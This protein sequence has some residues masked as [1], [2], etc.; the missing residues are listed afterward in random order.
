MAVDYA[1]HSA[2]IE[3][4]REELEE[5][6]SPIS[7]KPTEIPLHSTVSGEPIEGAEL[8]PSYWY[9]NL[10]Q[11]VLLEPVLRKALKQGHRALIEIGPHPV[12]AFGAQ[13]TIDDALKDPG[14]AT[15]LGTLRREEDEP[16]RFALSLAE[17]HANGIELDWEAFFKGTE[18]KR[19]PLPTYPFQRERYWLAPS[20]GSEVDPLASG[21]AFADHPLL[22]ATVDLAGGEEEGLLLTGRISLQTHPWLADHAVA[23]SVLLPGTAFLEMALRAGAQSGAETV[24][25][26]TLQKPLILPEPGAVAIQVSVSGPTEDGRR[27]LAIYS[28]IEGE[29]GAWARHASGTLSSEPAADIE[30]L[31]AWPPEGSEPL[32]VEY[33]YDVLAEHGFEYGPLFQ[34]LTAA[35]RDGEGVCVEVSLPEE[36]AHEAGRF[37]IHPALLDSALHGMALVENDRPGELRLPFSWSGVSVRAEGASGLRVRLTPGEESMALQIA[38]GDGTP[39]AASTRLSCGRWI[40]L[41]CSGQRR[42]VRASCGSTGPRFPSL[43]WTTHRSRSSFCAAR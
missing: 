26:L 39:L 31:E 16:T 36:S 19:V 5:A 18:A 17:A 14:E 38:D 42:R 23:G 43:R 24:E 40:P 20:M 22:S 37:A 12:L 2:Q 13:E 9:R 28:R 8:G 32:A 3:D 11:T 7:P 27:E 15:L 34:G 29:E 30:P 33:L 4:L 6:F 41:D 21:Q 35:W 1:A 25:E 10:R